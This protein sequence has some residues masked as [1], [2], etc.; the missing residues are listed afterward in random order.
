MSQVKYRRPKGYVDKHVLEEK[1]KAEEEAKR[2]RNKGAAA[3]IDRIREYKKINKEKRLTGLGSSVGSMSTTSTSRSPRNSRGDRHG[4]AG[5]SGGGSH[6]GDTNEYDDDFYT[7]EN[8]HETGQNSRGN[9][10]HGN[11]NNNHNNNHHHHQHNAGNHSGRDGGEKRI[12]FQDDNYRRSE[13][14]GEEENENRVPL[15]STSR[16][17]KLTREVT[18]NNFEEGGIGIIGNL[19][20]QVNENIVEENMYLNAQIE[21]FLIN[22]DFLIVTAVCYMGEDTLEAEA[23]INSEELAAISGGELKQASNLTLLSEIAQEVVDNVEVKVDA[24]ADVRLVLNLLSDALSTDNDPAD[25]NLWNMSAM[26]SSQITNNEEITSILLPGKSP[27]PPLIFSLLIF[28]C[29]NNRSS[30]KSV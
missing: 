9:T 28:L 11:N 20:P 24:N 7:S 14:D 25:P 23:E 5:N 4:R 6:N 13:D 2:Q 19:A 30:S 8:G 10:G 1:K 12:A 15:A 18:M 16:I 3:H 26:S 17:I 27:F 22:R 29:N 21:C